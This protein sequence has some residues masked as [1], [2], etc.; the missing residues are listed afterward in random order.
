MRSVE[1][2]R[3][4]ASMRDRRNKIVARLE[5]Q[6]RLLVDPDVYARSSGWNTVPHVAWW[7]S[8]ALRFVTTQRIAAMDQKSQIR[9]TITAS[10]F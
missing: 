8:I 9:A 7:S 10:D 1:Y 6:K 5:E 2:P 4:A 3:S